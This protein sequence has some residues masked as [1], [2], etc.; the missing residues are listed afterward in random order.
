MR[1]RVLFKQMNIPSIDE[2][3]VS[4]DK[5]VAG[6][7]VVYDNNEGNIKILSAQLQKVISNPSQVKDIIKELVTNYIPVAVVAVPNI[8]KRDTA[9]IRAISLTDVAKVYPWGRTE[10]TVSNSVSAVNVPYTTLGSVLNDTSFVK[11][12]NYYSAYLPSDAYSC[13][14]CRYDPIAKYYAPNGACRD[15][16]HYGPSPYTLKGFNSGYSNSSDNNA[17]S[18]LNGQANTKKILEVRGSITTPSTGIITNPENHFL[19]AY[20]C[21]KYSTEGLSRGSWYLGAAG[22]FGYVIARMKTINLSLSI[23]RQIW[24]YEVTEINKQVKDPLYGK[25]EEYYW[26]SSTYRTGVATAINPITG[27]ITTTM[28]RTEYCRIRAFTQISQFDIVTPD[29]PISPGKPIS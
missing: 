11:E 17:L 7:I 25:Y 24:G 27:Y 22:E 23:I 10:A 21:N 18:D 6:D 14:A 16:S 4:I 5:A 12:G 29:K 19:P 3:L 8:T 1:R 2:M 26:T 20:Y 15:L 9:N 28:P 13:N